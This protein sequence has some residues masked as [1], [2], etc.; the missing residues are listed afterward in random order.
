MVKAKLTARQKQVYD[1][2]AASILEKSAPPTI[3]E[4]GERF[5]IQSTN[6]VRSIL[7]ALIKKGYI[8]KTPLVSR[9][10]ELATRMTTSVRQL[11]LVGAVPA[12]APLLADENVEGSIAVDTTFLPSG[13]TYSLRVVGESMIGAGIVDGDFVV[14]RKQD[15][16]DAGD[17]VVAVIGD[18]ATVKRY[19]PEPDCIRLEPENDA[20]G[21]IIV[22]NDTPGFY[23]AGKVVGLLR[24]M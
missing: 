13:E 5:S 1:F 16:A 11:R 7:A 15:S 19:Y 17:I 20:F 10:I 9:G 24:R 23:I 12:G 14:V 4:I 22:E 3:R 6:G 18:E 8:K 2:I 21:P